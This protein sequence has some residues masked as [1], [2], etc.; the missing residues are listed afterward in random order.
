M[1]FAQRELIINKAQ[2]KSPSKWESSG[3]TV[4]ARLFREDYKVR[5]NRAW[6]RKGDN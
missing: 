1:P 2:A 5:G 4:P 3:F 6:R